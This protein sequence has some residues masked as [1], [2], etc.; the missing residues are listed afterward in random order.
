MAQALD[1]VAGAAKPAAWSSRSAAIR[2]VDDRAGGE[3]QRI[4]AIDPFVDGPM[5][6]GAA[7]RDKFAANVAA[8]ALS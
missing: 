1:P 6:G 2:A 7:T 5:F 3:R 8:S 4:V